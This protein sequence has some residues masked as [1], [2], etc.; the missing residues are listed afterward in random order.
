MVMADN[1]YFI[2]P[3]NGVLSYVYRMSPD[4]LQVV[5]IT[6]GHYFLPSLGP[7]FQGRDVFAPIAAWFSRGVSMWKFGETIKDYQ[8]IPL[9]SPEM[10][11]DGSM[12][13]EVIHIDR[14]GNAITNITR[15]EVERGRAGAPFRIVFRGKE[16]PFMRF[17]AEAEGKG[18]CMLMNSSGFLEIF[19]YRGDASS[20]YKI[21]RGDVVELI[22]V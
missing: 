9:P 2:G 21:S 10:R 1:H 18:L 19:I 13:G 20:E 8:K 17:Y 11:V 12:K 5:H 15:D 4:M 16:V 22:S 7:T 6:A 3:D 14:F